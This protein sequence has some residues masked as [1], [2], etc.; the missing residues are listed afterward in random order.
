VRNVVLIDAGKYVPAHMRLIQSVNL[1]IDEASLTGESM[2]VDK[3]A[4]IP[5]DKD[6]P[7]GNRRNSALMSTL[8]TYGRRKDLVMGCFGYN[9]PSYSAADGHRLSI[10]KQTPSSFRTSSAFSIAEGLL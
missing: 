9:L 8:T 6:I 4:D 7:L 5:L 2:P 3:N 10:S 1:K